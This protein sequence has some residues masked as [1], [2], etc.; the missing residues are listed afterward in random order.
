MMKVKNVLI[1]SKT[2]SRNAYIALSSLQALI[3][4]GRKPPRMTYHVRT[5]H[6]LLQVESPN[7]LQVALAIANHY[8]KDF[9]LQRQDKQY[10]AD[11]KPVKIKDYGMEQPAQAVNP[12]VTLLFT[13]DTYPF[14]L[15]YPPSNIK[16][17]SPYFLLPT[18]P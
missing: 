6:Y 14:N 2:L 8:Q 7:E 13:L 4:N 9:S 3:K 16:H 10:V 5:I 12:Q 1:W 17:R 18:P 11:A 15:T